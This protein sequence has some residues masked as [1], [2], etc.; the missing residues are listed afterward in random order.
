M[1]LP[2]NSS[3][4]ESPHH[5]DPAWDAICDQ[6]ACAW[7]AHPNAPPELSSVLA[8]QLAG[9]S[10]AQAKPLVR[11][12]LLLDREYR[13]RAGQPQTADAYRA[14]LGAHAASCEDLLSVPPGTGPSVTDHRGSGDATRFADAPGEGPVIG[15]YELCGE[16]ARGGMGVVYRARQRSLNRMVALK[17]VL[18]AALADDETIRRFRIEA[19]SAAKLDHPGIVP[20][21]E[22]GEHQGQHFFAM[23]LIDGQSLSAWAEEQS[24]TEREILEIV[25]SIAAAVSHAHQR[26]ILHRD[27]KP[28]NVLVD[29]EGKPI[30]TDF[31][32]ARGT[33]ENR[34]VTQTGAVVGTPGFMSPEQ[35]AGRGVTTATDVYSLGAILYFLLCGRAP[36]AEETVLGTLLSVIE[37]PPLPL[38][39]I[40]PQIDPDLEL[41][42]LHALAKNPDQRY[43]SAAEF[44]ADL[45]AYQRGEPLRV[46]PPSLVEIMRIWVHSNFGNIVWIPVIA[47]VVGMLS[48]GLLWIGLIGG[49]TLQQNLATYEGFFPHDR[50][51]LLRDYSWVQPLGIPLV[52]LVTTM[53]GWCTAWLVGTKN[54]TADLG[55]GLAVGTLAGLI[56]C[57]SGLGPMMIRSVTMSID[58]D[59]ALLVALATGERHGETLEMIASRYP[60]L[61]GQPASRTALLLGE[62]IESDTFS[63]TMV[64]SAV[65]TV[66]TLFLFG[67]LGV[68]ET[69][70][71]GPLIRCE[72]PFHAVVSYICFTITLVCLWFLIGSDVAMRVLIGSGHL[73]RWLIPLFFL[74]SATLAILFV[75]QR[76]PL[77]AQFALTVIAVAFFAGYIYQ[78][79]FTESPPV[80]ANHLTAIR[81]AQAKLS[82]SKNP[83]GD[84]LA[85]ARAQREYGRYQAGLGNP[86][87]ALAPLLDSLASLQEALQVAE[88]VRSG[89]HSEPSAS[90]QSLRAARDE[91]IIDVLAAANAS[92]DYQRA[93]MAVEKYQPTESLSSIGNFHYAYTLGAL[94]EQAKLLDV[95]QAL[96]NTSYLQRNTAAILVRQ[97]AKGYAAAGRRDPARWLREMSQRWTLSIPAITDPQR[98]SLVDWIAGDQHFRLTSFDGAAF[99]SSQ[100]SPLD[101]PAAVEAALL[102]AKTILSEALPKR[103]STPIG[104]YLNVHSSLANSSPVIVYV[105]TALK[106]GREGSIHFQFASDCPAR[107]WIDGMLVLDRPQGGTLVE[108]RTSFATDL[109]SGEHS[110]VI[111]MVMPG[112][113]GGLMLDAID[114]DGFPML[115]WESGEPTADRQR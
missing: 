100:S 89:E 71:A 103:A 91:G 54:R 40:V 106:V 5:W 107:I 86:D 28:A 24:R 41:I 32:L 77:L 61:E 29:R 42:C 115:I 1:T 59:Q 99:E 27:L 68:C 62:K 51:W 33:A 46:R 98:Q 34:Q 6:F 73:T 65:G 53:L 52:L 70:V 10:V 17:M 101:Q 58:Q 3:E 15:D 111:K 49:A 79:W 113:G 50:P 22:I 104:T 83:E 92:G 43:A 45:E 30:V 21:Y 97:A 8:D 69:L 16:I 95:A 74:A 18:G 81:A 20:I 47:L 90:L 25:R 85:V 78:N 37:K 11:E 2:R 80:V 105:Q 9:L 110:L 26:G 93:A 94:D 67:F 31:G 48:G 72:K 14:V 102:A 109:T 36:H 44:A 108:N 55:S 84:W 63:G 7:E 114:A 60:A 88:Q 35:A 82:A 76:R 39:K 38:R 57:A 96:G 56:A 13:T 66:L 4:S 87:R 12:L 75:I 19:E 23:K 112:S 64:G